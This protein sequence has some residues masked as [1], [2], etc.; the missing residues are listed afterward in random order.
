MSSDIERVMSVFASGVTEF[1]S[2]G[3]SFYGEEG[4]SAIRARLA[5]LMERYLVE[6]SV[7][8]IA[9]EIRGNFGFD[10]GWHDYVLTPKDRGG[11]PKRYRTRY[12]A[13]WKKTADGQWLINRFMDN[14][15]HQPILLT[16]ELAAISKNGPRLPSS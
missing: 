13:T 3:P 5:A 10:Y 11:E 2:G 7:I 6:L 8:I 9:Y 4:R 15:E 16:D 1:T 12:M 14:L